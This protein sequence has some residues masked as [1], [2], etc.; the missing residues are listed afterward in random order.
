MAKANVQYAD[1]N[2]LSDLNKARIELAWNWFEFHAKQRTSFYNYFL[3]ITGI[4]LNGYFISFQHNLF[5]FSIAVA[6]FGMINTFCFWSIDIR[7][8]RLTS[9]AE[10]IIEAIETEVLFRGLNNAKG[11]PLGL[12]SVDGSYG[13]R[14]G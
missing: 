4:L 10:N 12:L 1:D 7:N 5:S 13:M 2:K 3:I 9:Y 8:R 11:S 6:V 14:E